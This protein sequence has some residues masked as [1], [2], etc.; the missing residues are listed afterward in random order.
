[1]TRP[2]WMPGPKVEVPPQINR[3]P[4]YSPIAREHLWVMCCAYR[5]QPSTWDGGSSLHL[6]R[7]NL[8][9]LDGPG[10]YYCMEDYSARLAK[11]P[12]PGDKD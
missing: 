3:I 8:V 10:C 5:V 11:R 1:M 7:E 9:A 2:Q 4:P 12:C 6:D